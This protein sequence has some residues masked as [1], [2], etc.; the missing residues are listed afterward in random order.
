[1]K[2]NSL[3]VIFML[4][5]ILAVA[6]CAHL[7]PAP[8]ER[9]EESLRRKV[10]MEWEA[11]VNKDWGVVYD[12]AVDEYKKKVDRNLLIQRA[13]VNVQ[14]FS[15][16]EV[17]IIEPGRK[18]LAVVDYRINQM[19][20]DFNITSRE[21]WLWENGGWHLNLLPTLRTPFDKKR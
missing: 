7:T 20:F 15:I 9:S 11:K 8:V 16:K 21:E 4:A 12:L 17:K 18:A 1:M 19:G 5:T 2:K 3:I 13:N 14:E 6:G 10:K